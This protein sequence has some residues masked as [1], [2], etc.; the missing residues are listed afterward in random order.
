MDQAAACGRRMPFCA[1]MLWLGLTSA[2]AARGQSS[3]T[4]TRAGDLQ[5]G[6]GFIFARSTNT[7]AIPSTQ[8]TLP[9]FALYGLFDFRPHVGLEADFRQVNDSGLNVYER[10]YEVGGRY[11][12]HYGDYGFNPYVKV[13]YGRGVYNYPGNVATLAYTV[14]TAGAGADVRVF[15]SF[16]L[17]LDYEYQ[18]WMSFPRGDLHP[19]GLS[20]GVT[21]HFFQNC[22]TPGCHR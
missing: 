15:S 8:L 20:V 13:L 18:T 22:R 12:R 6:G 19:N 1:M 10:T 21:Y 2:M 14:Y 9:G 11:V 3:P 7:Q 16:N 5:V 17:R 4:A